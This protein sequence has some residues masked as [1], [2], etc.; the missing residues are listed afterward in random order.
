MPLRVWGEHNLFD[1]YVKQTVIPWWPYG[2][3]RIPH[4]ANF[5]IEMNI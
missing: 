3:I 5:F 4:M 1:F 2:M